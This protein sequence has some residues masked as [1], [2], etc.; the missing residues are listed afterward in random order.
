MNERLNNALNWVT[1]RHRFFCRRAAWVEAYE[2]DTVLAFGEGKTEMVLKANIAKRTLAALI[3]AVSVCG[4]LGSAS[5]ADLPTSKSAP[6]PPPPVAAPQLGFFVKFGLAY[7]INTTS[8]KIYSQSAQRL[9]VGDTTQ[10]LVSGLGA[11]LSNIATLGVEVGYFV[12]PNIS[13]DVS[14]GFPMWVKDTT[15]GNPPGNIP[16]P[17]TRLGSSLAG[18]IPVTVDYHF[19]QFGWFQPYFGAGLTPVFSFAQ[20]NG[21]DTSITV[22][23]TVGLVLQAG[24]DV[25][26]NDH[27]G[28]SFDVKKIFANAKDH[29]TGVNLATIGIPLQLPLATTQKV[30]FQP[31]LLST[32]VVYRF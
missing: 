1:V 25:M 8:S 26:L 15:K 21:F 17:G 27:W 18:L 23:P 16:P 12:T 31:W 4:L 7:A 19:T 28:W 11:N 10:Y 30:N 6:P 24:T 20:R 13:I 9:A 29:G 14:G 22:D 32:G 3:G 5:A 2:A